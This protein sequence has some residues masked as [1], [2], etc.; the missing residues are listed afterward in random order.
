[1]RRTNTLARWTADE[2][3]AQDVEIGVLR[4]SPNRAVD[5]I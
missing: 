2:F 5:S 3:A 4:R 1:M